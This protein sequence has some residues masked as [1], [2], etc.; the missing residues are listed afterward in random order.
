MIRV[1]INHGNTSGVN[2]D[3]IA[4]MV[5]INALTMMLMDD[6]AIVCR[7]PHTDDVADQSP[8]CTTQ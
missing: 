3:I 5:A 7:A 6:S 2:Y 1:S 4:N 8:S